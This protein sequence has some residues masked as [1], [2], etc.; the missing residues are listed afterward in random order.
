MEHDDFDH[1][2]DL[3]ADAAAIRAMARGSQQS[4][5][6]AMSKR[7]ARWLSVSAPISSAT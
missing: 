6:S 1:G 3:R 2:V 4:T 5:M 7:I